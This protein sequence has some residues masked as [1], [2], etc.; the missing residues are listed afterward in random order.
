MLGKSVLIKIL[1]IFVLTSCS[2]NQSTK[3]ETKQYVHEESGIE[4]D[5][6]TSWIVTDKSI[7]PNATW[8]YVQETEY[9]VFDGYDIP[10]VMILKLV[11][12]DSQFIEN[13]LENIKENNNGKELKLSSE[14]INN[15]KFIKYETDEIEEEGLK[16][17][18][19]FYVFNENNKTIL[20]ETVD[21]SSYKDDVVSTI[22]NSITF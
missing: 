9:N 18:I 14:K 4:F 1:L 2:T 16:Y 5:Y 12:S 21:H 8:L 15:Y 10:T 22:I 3:T 11:P 6:P 17:K 13:Y 7:V 20:I 19:V